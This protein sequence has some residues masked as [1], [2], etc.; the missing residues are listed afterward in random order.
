MKAYSQDLRERVLRAVDQGM[1]R[2]EIVRVLGV[3]LA[4]I[5]RY[6]KQHRET[7]HVQPKAIPGRPSKKIQPLQAGLLGQLEA[8]PDA[9]LAQHCQ[10]WEQS[11]GIQV[12][13]WSLSRAI[14]RLNWTRKKRRSGRQNGTKEHGLPIESTSNNWMRTRS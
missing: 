6:L 12:S 8:F 9:T 11:H 2:S 7:G 5:G 3:S 13:R 4:T 10:S 14:Q 1:P